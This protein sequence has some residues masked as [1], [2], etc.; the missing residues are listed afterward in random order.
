M[1]RTAV[2]HWTT[3]SSQYTLQSSVTQAL[4]PSQKTR[5]KQLERISRPHT[6]IRT[7]KRK[8]SWNETKE[9]GRLEA[10]MKK[11]IRRSFKSSIL[12][13]ATFCSPSLAEHIYFCVSCL[14]PLAPCVQK[15]LLLWT[16]TQ[17]GGFSHREC[18]TGGPWDKSGVWWSCV[19]PPS[20]T[21]RSFVCYSYKWKTLVSIWLLWL[22]LA[23]FVLFNKCLI[24]FHFIIS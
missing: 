19:Y 9:K 24:C 1:G 10:K 18:E 7:A 2:D 22:F 12:L 17:R 5:I 13:K 21:F 6:R 14:R 20:L 16:V 23:V 3:D 11:V 4:H 15:A 8:P